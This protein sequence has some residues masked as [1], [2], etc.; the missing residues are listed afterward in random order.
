ML[1]RVQLEFKDKNFVTLFHNI[2]SGVRSSAI[3]IQLLTRLRCFR[4]SH[5]LSCAWANRERTN[6]SYADDYSDVCT[7][8]TAPG[9]EE[10]ASYI[11]TIDKRS[12][13]KLRSGHFS[14]RV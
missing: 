14:L 10:V 8:D 4:S 12:W 7:V 6:L 9:C 1:D 3:G 11:S 5:R 13:N 2:Q